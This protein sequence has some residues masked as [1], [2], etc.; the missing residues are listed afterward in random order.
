MKFC[1]STLVSVALLPFLVSANDAKCSFLSAADGPSFSL[2]LPLN[3]LSH[4][5]SDLPL[6]FRG[7]SP[8]VTRTQLKHGEMP[9][10][11]I[12]RYSS[13]PDV[14]YDA[15]ANRVV[16]TSSTSN[17]TEMD[18][19]VSKT[20]KN[21]PGTDEEERSS[22]A[23]GALS[24]SFLGSSFT[25]W[26]TTA[27]VA[28]MARKPFMMASV[29][30][31]AGLTAAVQAHEDDCLP[32]VQVLV[33]APAA[34]KGAVDVC[35]EEIN[36]PAICP[37]P[38]PTYPTCNNPAPTC[39]IAVVGAG[40]GG[41]YT[42]LRLVDEG[43]VDASDVCVFDMTERVGGRLMSLRGL[44]PEDDLVVDAGGYRTW[45]QFTPTSH[46]L[47]TEYLGIPM[48]C[49]D[50]SEP[51]EVY[52]IVDEEGTKAGFTLFVET[53]MQR[54]SDKGTC[55]YPYHELA[56]LENMD[57]PE[58]AIGSS[59]K[60]YFANGVT[61]TANMAVILNVPQRP[62]MNIVRN[63]NF[64]DKGM[65]DKETLD[66]LH[67]VQTVIATKLYLY[68]PR[69]SVFW[70][71]LGLFS[72][73]FESEGDA[74]NMLL[75]GRYHDGQVKCD[76]DSDVNTCHGFLLAVYANDLSGNKAQYFRRFQRERP[77]PV[78]IISDQ[79][80]EGTEFL[81]HAHEQLM[82]YHLY[83]KADAPYTGF[84][85]SQILAGAPPP[86]F[87]MLSTWNTAIPWAGG[88]WH[89]W[90]DTS[91]ID[92]AKQPFIEDNIFVV[93][94]AFS[95][96][97]GWAEGSLKV[98]DEILEDHF[99]VVRPWNF[100]VNDLNQIVQQTNSQECAEGGPV[101]L[102]SDA[103]GGEV[104]AETAALLCFTGEALVE[105]A[106]G[107]FKSI[108]SVM[109]GDEVSTGNG[110]SGSVTETLEHAVDAV[111]QVAKMITHHG[112][113]VGTPDH[114][115]FHDGE[116][117][118]FGRTPDG[119]ILLGEHYVEKLYNLEIDGH[120]IDESST[121]SYVVNGVIASGLGDNEEL[122]LLF[123]RQKEWKALAKE[124]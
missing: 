105:M 65:L 24:V 71:K 91:N 84:E 87:A 114:P 57:A 108:H 13:R 113:L 25:T 21:P 99:D 60:L 14:F 120:I 98:A 29:I 2:E 61:A 20:T 123:P 115:V 119:K 48:G 63:S 37:D 23:S 27:L 85:A 19:T 118:E 82:N 41:L 76:D 62:L 73:D 112:V 50:D 101:Q 42:A 77:E 83:E 103:G 109:K 110:H 111:V 74:R 55:F 59:T 1:L 36:E 89:A 97:Q 53:M 7:I 16:V 106:D 100:T 9:K 96:M 86:S 79:D 34:Y 107:T 6:E 58:N 94:E 88:A 28:G 68:Y 72:G 93:N 49:Y 12:Q 32:V 75:S 95:L 69:G 43:K 116:W 17:C 18:T 3:V 35:L 90:T 44:G 67:S 64:D 122:N 5:L 80:M 47:I 10:V 102:S 81:K 54:L 46:A 117:V 39:E 56:S 31:A 66:A 51:C 45:P 26:A 15:V 40:A 124:M 70:H 22:I 92:L 52:N 78:T 121:H 30:I 4:P 8:I 104:D 38:F 33:S 11:T